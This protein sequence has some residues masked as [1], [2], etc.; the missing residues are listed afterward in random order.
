[1]RIVA[2]QISHFPTWPLWIAAGV[3]QSSVRRA[4]C[5]ARTAPAWTPTPPRC[6]GASCAFCKSKG[7]KPGSH[8]IIGSKGLETG[9][10]QATG[11]LHSTCTAPRHGGDGPLAGGH[12]RALVKPRH[13]LAPAGAQ[14]HHE[15]QPRVGPEPVGRRLKRRGRLRKITKEINVL[16][17]V[18]WW[19]GLV[20]AF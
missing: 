12:G 8:H 6:S 20:L 7:L 5:T 2:A 10:F 19:E 3:L 1:M 13:A 11:Q 15:H 14:A 16:F 17:F 9:R 4:P 18:P